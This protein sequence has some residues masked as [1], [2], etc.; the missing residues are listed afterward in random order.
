[1]LNHVITA[2]TSLSTLFALFLS[3]G[4]NLFVKSR[5]LGQ[6]TA[7]CGGVWSLDKKRSLTA[8]LGG[9]GG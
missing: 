6:K 3:R 4:K 1:M 2:L 8:L 7:F 9:G 5:F